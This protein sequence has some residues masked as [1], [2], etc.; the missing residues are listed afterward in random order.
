MNKTA[1]MQLTV[2]GGETENKPNKWEHCTVLLWDKYYGKKAKKEKVLD[3]VGMAT[4]DL[5]FEIE[6]EE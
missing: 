1:C 5:S 3:E 6:R 4:V 2:N